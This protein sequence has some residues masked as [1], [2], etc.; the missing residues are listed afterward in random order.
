[1][2]PTQKLRICVCRRPE[3]FKRMHFKEIIFEV[4]VHVDIAAGRMEF[5]M[6]PSGVAQ[7]VNHSGGPLIGP[8]RALQITY[9]D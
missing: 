9:V 4:I 5:V 2:A 7:Q 8:E 3:E 1:M 6:L